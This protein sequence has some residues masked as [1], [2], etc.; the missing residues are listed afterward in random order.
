MSQIKLALIG[1]G[2]T[3]SRTPFMHVQEATAQGLDL[4]YELWDHRAVELSLE[5]YLH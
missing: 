4:I 1:A 5:A 2:I 3:R